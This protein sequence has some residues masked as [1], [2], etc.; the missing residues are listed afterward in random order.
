[1]TY[2][3]FYGTLPEG[4]LQDPHI[5]YNPRMRIE[6]LT[7]KLNYVKHWHCVQ[8]LKDKARSHDALEHTLELRALHVWR[9]LS[10]FRYVQVVEDVE[11][12]DVLKEIDAGDDDSH[13]SIREFERLYTLVDLSNRMMGKPKL[14]REA[15]CLQLLR[16]KEELEE[17]LHWCLEDD[18]HEHDRLGHI[19]AAKLPAVIEELD[20]ELQG[21][22][23]ARHKRAMSFI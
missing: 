11:E 19:P 12:A 4:L 16:D 6:S 9:L 13:L 20:H 7:D 5:G 22:Q 17:A 23:K 8:D 10:L 21:L 2:N 15:Y 14:R 1:M 3:E 18:V